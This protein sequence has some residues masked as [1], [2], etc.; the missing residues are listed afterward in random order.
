MSSD[1][2]PTKLNHAWWNER[3]ALHRQTPLYQTHIDRL[4]G[5]GLSL[6]PLEVSELGDI[7]GLRVLHVQCHI[8]TDTLS[9]SR[10]GAEVTGVD[11]SDVAIAEARQLS[12]DLG[13][14]AT[15]EH[16]DIASLTQ[17]HAE[18]FDVIFTSH[19]VLSWL[20]DLAEWAQQ[21]AGCLK[22]G[23]RFYLSE[24][25]PLIWALAE[26]GAVQDNG[27]KLELPYLAQAEP[28]TF[29]DSGSYA[30]RAL[31]TEANET[32]EWSWGIGDVVNAATR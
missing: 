12:A 4:R 21:I 23:G 2:S 10:L 20:P 28:S 18:A 19:G 5:G 15:F 29:V 3:A 24:S 8:G 16:S 25:H 30:N 17:R 26:E 14:P 6:L 13:I 1:D 27:L 32:T 31:P 11:F 7:Q 22:S 9:L